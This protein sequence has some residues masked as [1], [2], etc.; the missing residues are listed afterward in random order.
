MF[1]LE[2]TYTAPIER[3][4][5]ALPDHIAWLEKQYAA[6]YFLAS[7]RKVPRDGGIMLAVAPDRATIEAVAATDPFVT[8]DVCEYRITEF[9]PTQTA[10]GLEQYREQPPA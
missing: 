10:Q 3:V 6:G 9:V 2:V 4:E 7:G 8:A 5:A 1:V